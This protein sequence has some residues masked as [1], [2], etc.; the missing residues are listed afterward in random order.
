MGSAHRA[1]NAASSGDLSRLDG[2]LRRM[3]PTRLL[4]LIPLIGSHVSKLDF[5]IA[6]PA[7]KEGVSFMPD[8]VL[9]ELDIER[10]NEPQL[11]AVL[12][13]SAVEAVRYIYSE[14][15]RLT[16]GGA[17]Y[18]P[19]GFLRLGIA[20][21]PV[22]ASTLGVLRSSDERVVKLAPKA[23]SVSSMLAAALGGEPLHSLP[24][25]LRWCTD[26]PFKLAEIA[27]E[28]LSLTALAFHHPPG[29]PGGWFTVYA[30]LSS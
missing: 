4:L 3:N 2:V 20:M 10:G 28:D 26:G 30:H 13:D 1:G 25:R 27:C 7:Y 29:W 21:P 8:M 24:P 14:E 5:S 6:E 15:D 22:F 17:R 23:R 9:F 12:V 19:G 16:P 11:G 18:E